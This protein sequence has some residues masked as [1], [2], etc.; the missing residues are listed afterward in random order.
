MDKIK[1]DDL[2]NTIPNGKK[3]EYLR[4]TYINGIVNYHEEFIGN[5]LDYNDIVVSEFKSIIHTKNNLIKHLKLFSKSKLEQILRYC[6][7]SDL[8]KISNKS[9]RNCIIEYYELEFTKDSYETPFLELNSNCE[10]KLHD[11]QE[12][13]RRK[14]INMMFSEGKKKF[15]IHMPTGSG[16]TR[17]AAEIIIDFIRFSS[18]SSLL[19]EKIKIIW[20]AQSAELCQQAFRT[21]QNLYNLKGTT[22]LSF[23]NYYGDHDLNSDITNN[24][25]IIFTSIQKLLL[26]YRTPL[27]KLIR[28]D[29]YLVIVDEAHRSVAS[30]WVKALDFFVEN[31]SV[32]LIGLTATPGSGSSNDSTT[33]NLSN[34]YNNNKISLL[35]GFYCEISKPI[36]F[37]VKRGFLAEIE[38][39]DIQSNT[40]G[41][42][43][44]STDNFGNIKFENSTLNQLSVDAKRNHT[45]VSIIK[46]HIDRNH[47]ILV[48]TCEGFPVF[49]TV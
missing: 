6:N 1:I 28:N 24:P 10:N 32:N 22:D 12:R 33:N 2:I 19:N 25:A 46:K 31:K 47:K 18:S 17:T 3:R 36:S 48:F 8:S 4:D 23:G 34:Y 35:D 5:D 40:A 43:G 38:R 26:N 20:V 45:I 29:N 42:N 14:V 44:V 9:I 15:L 39:N 49:H 27:W 16:K 7:F 21:V 11:F 30:E 41:L 37:L 13:I